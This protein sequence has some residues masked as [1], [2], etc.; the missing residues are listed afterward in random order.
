MILIRA[1]IIAAMC[2]LAA[3]P[4]RADFDDGME[5]Y[6]AGDYETALKVWFSLADTRAQYNLGVLYRDGVGVPV[7]YVKAASWFR[8]AAEQGFAQAQY[9]LGVMY[10]NGQGLSKDYDEAVVWF[11]QAAE[12]GFD[13][14]Q[15]DL[16][17]MYSKG[18]GVIHGAKL[19]HAN[20]GYC[21]A[22][23]G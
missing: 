23:S 15:S 8:R 2:L 7:D 20:G 18:W 1:V 10:R 4:V 19:V 22:V 3:V 6:D 21:P 14:A 13:M 12:Q 16:G 5:A 11:R 9:N 17:A